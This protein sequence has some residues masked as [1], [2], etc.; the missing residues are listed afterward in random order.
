MSQDLHA[1]RRVRGARDDELAIRQAGLEP[2]GETGYAPGYQNPDLLS[3]EQ[4]RRFP[5]PVIGTPASAQ[6]A[7][8]LAPDIRRHWID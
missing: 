6:R 7:A 2:L 5:E 3:N 1:A 4:V 8:D